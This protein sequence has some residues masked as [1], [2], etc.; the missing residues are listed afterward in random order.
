MNAEACPSVMV[1]SVLHSTAQSLLSLFWKK[2]LV[3]YCIP[4]RSW[5]GISIAADHLGMLEMHFKD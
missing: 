3:L 1:I 5:C 4:L 2:K